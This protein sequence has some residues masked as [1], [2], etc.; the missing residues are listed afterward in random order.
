M[1]VFGK[2]KRIVSASRVAQV[3]IKHERDLVEF[4]KI[5]RISI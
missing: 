4:D 1:K 5:L 2:K 3:R